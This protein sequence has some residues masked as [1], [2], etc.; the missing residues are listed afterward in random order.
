MKKILLIILC[1]FGLGLASCNSQKSDSVEVQMFLP[2]GTPILSVA[3]ILDEGFS[4]ENTT[5]NYNIVAAA[6]IAARVSQ[7]A[8]DLAIMPTTA[9][10]TIFNKGVKI[11]LASV[12]VFGNLYITGTHELSNLSHL[13]GKKVYTT[14]GTT[15]ALLQYLLTQSN[16]AFTQG[17]EIVADKVVLCSKTDASEIIPLLKQAV[18]KGEEAYGVLGEPQVTKAQSAISDLKIT[19]DLQEE[20]KT[21]TGQDG[22]PQACLVVKENFLNQHKGYVDSLIAKLEGNGTYLMSHLTELPSV[23]KKFESALQAMTFTSDTIT[24]SNIRI[25]KASV[26]KDTVMSY[27]QALSKI[28]LTDEFF[29]L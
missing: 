1:I 21:V 2:D 22:Y 24:R 26:A 19:F 10:A 9:A 23:F 7:D 14:A 25:E 6:D 16:I 5:T 12:N 11:K 13:I 15:I 4:Y 17:E 20:Y 8:C 29:Y 18:T 27:V 3:S 28:T